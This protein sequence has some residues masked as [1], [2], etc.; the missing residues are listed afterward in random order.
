MKMVIKN[1]NANIQGCVF[2]IFNK[3]NLISGYKINLE[4]PTKMF[5][6]YEYNRNDR[7]KAL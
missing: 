4:N 7:N 6:R 3:I 2:S 1:F 5:F